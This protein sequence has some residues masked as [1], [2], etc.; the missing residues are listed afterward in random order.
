MLWIK[1]LFA[2][3]LVMVP[4]MSA[5]A[6]DEPKYRLVIHITQEDPKVFKQALNIA[7]NL[8]KNVGVDN[9]QVEIVAQGPG[10]KILS[11]G[12][13]EA[14]RIASLVPYDNVKFSACGMTMKGIKKKTG[15]DVVLLPDITVVPAGIV[16][17]MDLQQQGYSYIR[18]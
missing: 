16:R 15:K 5:Y 11:K 4:L 17:V 12:S 1:S 8:P 18:P 3:V 14:V 13:P 10:L 7:N 6:A 9:A 2:A